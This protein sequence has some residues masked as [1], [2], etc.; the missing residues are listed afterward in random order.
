MTD[1]EDLIGEIGMVMEIG[2]SEEDGGN[3]NVMNHCI[4]LL[5]SYTTNITTRLRADF[6]NEKK[7]NEKN[8]K[9]KQ[10]QIKF[11]TLSKFTEILDDFQFFKEVIK[12]SRSEY[13]KTGYL[14]LD[15]KIKKFLKESK[16]KIVNTKVPF[17][18]DLHECVSLMDEKKEKGT[19][20]KVASRGYKVGNTII[21]YPKVIVQS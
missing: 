16:I 8:Q 4:K 14:L 10:E 17:N 19:I 20:L 15:K 2:L 9:I 12:D 21:K 3:D 11:E 7:R 13:V 6:E 18:P 5:D 1:K